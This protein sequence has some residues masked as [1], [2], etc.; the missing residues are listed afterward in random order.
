MQRFGGPEKEGI[1]WRASTCRTLLVNESLTLSFKK[2]FKRGLLKK[3]VS[4]LRETLEK[5][6][7]TLDF[8]KSLAE[9]QH[10]LDK[11]K[12]TLAKMEMEKESL[13]RTI[14]K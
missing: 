10:A 1:K 7:P 2:G 6:E 5:Q 13:L 8:E 9:K 3:T 4:S 11:M 14:E 12:R